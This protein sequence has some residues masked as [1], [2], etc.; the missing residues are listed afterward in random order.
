[1]G[2]GKQRAKNNTNAPYNN[3]CDTQEG[4]FA[5]H[6][7]FS[8]NEDGLGASV[9]G[10]IEIFRLLVTQS[11]LTCKP[12]VSDVKPIRPTGHLFFIIAHS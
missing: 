10:N 6:D 3:I 4:V 2:D 5:S 7:C 9:N 8:G 1:M 11:K 12:T